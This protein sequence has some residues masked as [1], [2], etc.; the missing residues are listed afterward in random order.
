MLIFSQKVNLPNLFYTLGVF[1]ALVF[2]SAF[3]LP[4]NQDMVG[5]QPSIGD[6][7]RPEPGLSIS[8]GSLQ[9]DLLMT[10]EEAVNLKNPV[11][12]TEQSVYHGDRLYNANCAP[13]HGRVLDGKVYLG[14]VQNQVPGP[15]LFAESMWEKSDGHY[16]SYIHYGGMAI[17]PAYGWK[18]N[19]YEQWDIVNFIRK[20]QE[21]IKNK[22]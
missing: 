5:N 9:R 10:R 11:K 14:T 20:I 16:F 12:A 21:D 1:V 13:C 8:R 3:A 17:M 2:N 7:Q 4:F 22:K 15:A 18:L 19:F 6:I